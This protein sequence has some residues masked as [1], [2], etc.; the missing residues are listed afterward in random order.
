MK[1]I[2]IGAGIVGSTTAL[3]LA[4]RGVEVT[5]I[6]AEAEAGRGTSFANGSSLTPIH[7]EPWNPPG[8][9]RR[10]PDALFNRRAPARIALS[11]LPGLL[12][13]GRA[14]LRESA[15]ERYL[16]NARH[17]IR[18]GLYAKRCLLELRRR[19]ELD[20]D[21]FT[22]GS[23]ELYRTQEALEHIIDFRESLALSGIEFQT[24]D[25]E[26]IVA[27][28]PAL[29]PVVTDFSA[30]LWIPA[31]ESG[32]VR[33]FSVEA[34]ARAQQLGAAL[35]FG[36]PVKAI[37]TRSGTAPMVRTSREALHADQVVLCTGTQTPDLVAPLGLKVP[38][39]PVRGYS[40]TVP[41]APSASL[42]QVPLLDAERRFVVA[43]LGPRRLRIAG[44]ADFSG[45]K[46]TLD[47]RRLDL[48]RD[49]AENLLPGLGSVIRSNRVEAWSGLRPMTPD[50]P[51]LIGQT[52][53]DGLWLNTGHGAMGWTHAAG[54]A[55]LL[56][57]L[58]TGQAPA[59]DPAGLEAR[60]V[61]A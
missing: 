58:L 59:I 4:E 38:I 27:R 30:A 26:A 43:R 29:E 34:A 10:M 12:R 45:A 55:E 37:E 11:A 52:P 28:E 8:L 20:Y 41:V 19:H 54:S 18:L 49:A 16:D 35:R 57:D 14:F 1:V 6:D 25:A 9:L 47:R 33:R 5:L 32:D 24:L 40:L 22:E 3:V 42:P 48:L 15:P 17:C 50:G 31:H 36:T 51:P 13:W 61:F 2:I 21:Q 56:A 60:R 7:A 53:I 46:K 39:Y 23:M 44:F